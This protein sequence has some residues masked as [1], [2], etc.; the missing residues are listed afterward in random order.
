MKTRFALGVAAVALLA[1]L[2]APVRADELGDQLKILVDKVSPSIV[3]VKVVL[4]TELSMGGQSQDDESRHEVHGVVVDPDGL[5][6]LSSAGLSGDNLSEMMGGRGREI[7][8][9]ITPTDIKV[10]VEREEKEYSAFLAA[11]DSKVGLGFLKIEDL[12]DRKLPAVDFGAAVDATIGQNVAGVGRQRKG[13]DYAPYFETARVNG[14]IAKPRKAWM[15]DRSAA[16]MG[17]PV[18]TTAGKVIGVL[19]NIPDG[20]RDEEDGGGGGGGRGFGRMMRMMGGGGRGGAGSGFVLPGAVVKDLI[21]KA[22]AKAAEVAA[23]RAKQKDEDAKKATEGD[24]GEEKKGEDKKGADP[25]EDPDEG[26]K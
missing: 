13:Y 14:E 16:G 7:S 2:T 12:G 20:M 22:K 4:K 6:M 26:G 24:K 10:V 3:T 23:E 8:V 11:T 19:T 21:G 25:K 17:M 15:V 5:I 9:K 18:F 1:A